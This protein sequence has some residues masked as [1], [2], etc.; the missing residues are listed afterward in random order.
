MGLTRLDV[1]H[2][3]NLERVALAL[4]PGV[5]LLHGDNG[6]GKTSLLEAVHFLGSARSF[7]TAS[8]DSLIMRGEVQ[9]LVRGDVASDSGVSRIG[10]QRDRGAE[11]EIRINGEPCYKTSELARLL[12]TQVL[13]PESVDL[14]LGPPALRRR[15]LNWGLFHVKHDF[16]QLWDEANR[17]LRQRNQILRQENQSSQ[18]LHSWSVQLAALSEKLDQL[19]SGY[20]D[21]LEEPFQAVVEEISGMQAIRLEYFRGWER[22]GNLLEIYQKEVNSDQKRGFTQKGFQRADVRITVDGQ[23]AVKVCSRGELK[24]LVWSLILA[25]GNL[26]RSREDTK[27]LFLVDDLASEFDRNHRW[28]LGNYLVNHGHQVLI[29]G[30]DRDALTG[31]CED[32]F[33]TMFHVKHGDVE[34]EQ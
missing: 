17:C 13:G 10:I 23:P 4:A 19:R 14:L 31:C 26:T 21:S 25:Q 12:P 9:C 2:F 6:S 1:V 29:T 28:R 32:R 3:R 33:E 24:A 30:V 18:E 27:T 22:D 11:R 5:N 34:V 8:P 15:F 20:I 7:K 16:N